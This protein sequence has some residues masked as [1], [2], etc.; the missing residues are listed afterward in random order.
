MKT[1][2]SSSLEGGSPLL[3]VNQHEERSGVKWRELREQSRGEETQ[4]AQNVTKH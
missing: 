2:P 1:G 3:C 4:K